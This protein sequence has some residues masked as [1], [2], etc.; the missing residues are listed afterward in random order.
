L[1]LSLC[2]FVAANRRKVDIRSQD[3]G[4]PILVAFTTEVCDIEHLVCG[5]PVAEGP[6]GEKV[7]RDV[8]KE[9]QG[10]PG[11]WG[12]LR[13]VEGRVGGTFVERV[14]VH[15]GRHEGNRGA[16]I[17]DYTAGHHATV[18]HYKGRGAQ[19]AEARGK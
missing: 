18:G 19:T 17:E 9:I 13:V 2:G 6:L 11:A 16:S 15:V 14:R 5:S 10:S 3:Y 1:G 4:I 12:Q 7:A 8:P